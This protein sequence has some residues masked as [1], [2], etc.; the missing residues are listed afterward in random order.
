MSRADEYRAYLR[1]PQWREVRA[2]SQQACGGLCEFCGAV[3]TQTHHVR[4]PKKFGEDGTHNTL[5]V[6]DRCHKLSH[7]GREMLQITA[8]KRASEVSPLGADF[9]YVIVNGDPWA[10]ADNWASALKFPAPAYLRHAIDHA[11]VHVEKMGEPARG[12]APSGTILYSAVVVLQ[13]LRAVDQNYYAHGYARAASDGRMPAEAMR[14][15][16]QNYDRLFLWVSRLASK[17]LAAAATASQQQNATDPRMALAVVLQSLTGVQQEHGLLLERH[18]EEI[19]ELR[20]LVAKDP[21]A[22]LT[23]KAGCRDF[24]LD[25][26]TAPLAPGN[27]HNWETLLGNEL[28]AMGAIP[29]PRVPSRLSGCSVMA[30]VNTWRRSD[31]NAAITAIQARIGVRH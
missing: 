18:T 24:G 7:G 2:A 8:G 26:S 17:A 27:R 10:P 1:S 5:S 29:G 20:R 15:W 16:I 3:A 6:C 14:Q 21:H 4:Y 9:D 28:K 25:E 19:G 31:V 11:S 13:A 30:D 12:R 23:A 22:Y